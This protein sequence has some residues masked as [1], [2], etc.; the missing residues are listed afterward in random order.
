MEVKMKVIYQINEYRHT[1]RNWFALLYRYKFGNE[2]ILKAILRNGNCVQAPK[3]IFSIINGVRKTDPSSFFKGLFIFD[4]HTEILSFPY[5]DTVLK[6]KFFKD[7]IMNG[8]PS[9][10]DGDY[11]FLE[12][13][14]SC[15]VV[16]IGANIA[17]SSIFFA[18]K[19]ASKIISLEPYKYSYEMGLYNIELN[20]LENV[21][22]FINAAY[23]KDGYI[24]IE[25]KVSNIGSELKPFNG[26]IKI[27]IM[28][29]D[30][31]INKYIGVTFERLLLKMDCEGCEYNL[32]EEKNEV[33]KKF[34]KILIEYHY[35]YEKLEIKLKK[36][37]FKVKFTTPHKWKD[38]EG[39]IYV[40]GYLYA[41]NQDKETQM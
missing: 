41:V 26:G 29:I 9:S 10:F 24:E 4:K 17:D 27:P 21:I 5:N 28:S 13:F 11:D 8:E 40:Q 23:G 1:F 22:S 37:G 34:D 16:D 3:E 12:P 30:T 39:H 2:R 33:I 7:G 38:K 32:L 14:N 31:I 35:G 25:D 19:G 20:N 15:I 36:C 6:M 18:V